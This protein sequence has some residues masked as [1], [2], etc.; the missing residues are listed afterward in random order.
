M[1]NSD[2]ALLNLVPAIIAADATSVSRLLAESPELAKASFQSGATRGGANTYFLDT[3]GRYIYKGDTA[4]HIAAAAYQTE[5]AR[6]LLAAGAD[7]HARNRRGAEPLHAAAVGNPRS[8]A[9]NPPAQA[10]TIVCLIEAGADPNAVDM[11]GVTPLHRAVRTRCAEAARTLLARG[12]DPT[13]K[14]KSGSTP[15][16][17]AIHNT[18]RGGTGSQEAKSQQ[19]EIVLLLEQYTKSEPPH[20]PEL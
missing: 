12:A 18:G 8:P 13:R 17:L 2:Q 15:M 7:V 6:K 10:A 9:W 11:D 20:R 14:N 4:L 19:R 1:A 16:V 3:I 5:I